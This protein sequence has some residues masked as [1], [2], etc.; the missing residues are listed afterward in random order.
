MSLDQRKSDITAATFTGHR[1][2]NHTDQRRNDYSRTVESS[3]TP[4]TILVAL[5]LIAFSTQVADYATARFDHLR[6]A[7][8]ARTRVRLHPVA[9]VI[10][11]AGVALILIAVGVDWSTRMLFS[12]QNQ[13][14]AAVLIALSAVVV[15]IAVVAVITVVVVRPPADSYRLVRD[16]LIEFSGVRIHQ[17]QVDDFHARIAVIDA[18]SRDRKNADASTIPAA[19][20]LVARSPQRLI[21]PLISLAVALAGLVEQVNNP[22]H[23]WVFLLS[24]LILAASVTMGVVAVRASL[25]LRIAVRSTQAGYRRELVGLIVE[26]EKSSKKRVAGLGDRVARALSILRE[27]QAAQ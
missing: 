5:W 1:L 2:P 15:M 17:D 3:W 14:P 16:E 18:A 20:L 11:V 10:P 6:L 23:A 27:Q 7:R 25:A 21:A 4:L 24:L 8:G 9:W 26:A 13:L 12:D 19:L 22:D